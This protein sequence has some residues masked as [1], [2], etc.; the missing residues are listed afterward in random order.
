MVMA[1][2]LTT[3]ITTF[4]VSRGV[5]IV[6]MVCGHVIEG[7]VK[8]G[9]EVP[10]AFDVANEVFHTFRM[11]LFFFL[12]GTFLV[13]TM[14]RFRVGGWMVD[15]AAYLLYPYAVWAVIRGA[16]ELAAL[17]F[18]VG[19]E[20]TLVDVLV[21]LVWDPRAWYL[22]ALFLSF[23]VVGGIHAVCGHRRW[24]AAAAAGAVLV[25]VVL[26]ELPF[27]PPVLAVHPFSLYM[28]LGVLLSAVTVRA[29]R[30]SRRAAGITTVISVFVFVVVVVVCLPSGRL[31]VT[32]SGPF[33]L[34]SVPGVV[35]LLGA[36]RLLDGTGIGVGLGALGAWSLVIYVVHGI[37][38]S[39]TRAFLDRAGIDDA[40]VHVLAG[41]LAGVAVP[42][43]LAAVNERG[44]WLRWLITMPG[45]RRGRT[46]PTRSPASPIPPGATTGRPSS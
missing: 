14:K 25:L 17:R 18:G 4:D 8:T 1:P 31:D 9:H 19:E 28:I 36:G 3:R 34:A 46:G 13:Q 2:A 7:L 5:A 20:L 21:G 43:V 29:A 26:A 32:M 39:L 37:P 40:G 42:A 10:V 45:H 15:K 6:G 24:W 23:V 22:P 27:W 11:P 12:A 44:P 16:V 35:M 33:L 38:L 30:K 41:T